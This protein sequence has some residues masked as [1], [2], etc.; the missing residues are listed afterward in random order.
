MNEN[1]QTTAKSSNWQTEIARQAEDSASGIGFAPQVSPGSAVQTNEVDQQN[2]D[3]FYK[4]IK[5]LKDP[6]NNVYTTSKKLK[7]FEAFFILLSIAFGV[8]YPSFGY[9]KFDSVWKIMQP[10]L[11][12][13][14]DVILGIVSIKLLVQLKRKTNLASFQELGYYFTGDRSSIILIG[15][16]FLIPSLASAAYSIYQSA[17]LFVRVIVVPLCSLFLSEELIGQLHQEDDMLYYTVLYALIFMTY[18]VVYPLTKIQNYQRLFKYTYFILGS[19]GLT[20]LLILVMIVV[21]QTGG[22]LAKETK[23]IKYCQVQSDQNH[24]QV[25]HS[26]YIFIPKLVFALEFQ[27]YFL[28]VISQIEEPETII[29]D[30]ERDMD[31]QN[32][33]GGLYEQLQD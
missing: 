19:V 25:E 6:K 4:T 8:G 3:Q 14:L 18:V 11:I 22:V 7:P 27:F 31:D 23:D 29:M 1:Y 26:F 28:Q 24:L 10:I 30:N 20:I 13:L 16:Q 12:I 33:Q 21:N 9:Q 32:N 2:L 17:V 5:E 15:L